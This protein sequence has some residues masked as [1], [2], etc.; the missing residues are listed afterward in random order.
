[1]WGQR[2]ALALIFLATAGVTIFS[3]FVVPTKMSSRVYFGA[4][5]MIIVSIVIIVR[6]LFYERYPSTA[7]YLV[8][9]VGFLCFMEMAAIAKEYIDIRPQYERRM[10]LI[11]QASVTGL[12]S[13]RL[14]IYERQRRQHIWLRDITTDPNSAENMVIARRYGFEE[15]VGYG[16]EE[17]DGSR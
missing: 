8:G 7:K 2:F 4:G 6:M 15:V 13:V 1:L 10:E 9:V 5:M 16:L 17:G 14:P 12:K 11:E 3:F